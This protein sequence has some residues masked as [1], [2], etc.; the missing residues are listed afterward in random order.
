ML[1][2]GSPIPQNTLRQRRH[3]R[4]TEECLM[5]R[6]RNILMPK[7]LFL[8]ISLACVAGTSSAA[9]DPLAVDLGKLGGTNSYATAMNEKGQVVGQSQVPGDAEWRTFSWTPMGGMVDL[10]SFG[11]SQSWPV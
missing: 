6:D 4:R 2:G 9:Q 11:G 10:G 1:P 5:S 8:A 7:R 3:E